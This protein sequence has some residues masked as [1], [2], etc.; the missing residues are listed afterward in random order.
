MPRGDRIARFDGAA[1][2]GDG[3]GVF[4]AITLGIGASQRGLAQHVEGIAIVTLFL[5]GGACQSA[6]DVATHDELVPEDAHGLLERGARHRLTQF[7]DQSRVPGTRL[8]DL[9][10][11]ERNHATREHQSPGRGIDQQ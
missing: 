4:L 10:A 8:A 9:V 1:H 5:A 2:G 6:F 7:P 11:I 3:G